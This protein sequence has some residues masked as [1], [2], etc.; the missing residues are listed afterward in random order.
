MTAAGGLALALLF[1]LVT[2][3]SGLSV[4]VELSVTATDPG[5]QSI[6][7]GL[8]AP[9]GSGL[10]GS[11]LVAW[12]ALVLPVGSAGARLGF[13]A[14]SAG[15]SAAV[16]TFVL[17]RRLKFSS[18]SALIATLV[19]VTGGTGVALVA[20]GSPDAMLLPL[21]PGLL[22]CGL[23]W[24]DSSG[25]G[26][27]VVT[28]A[29]LT[30]VAVGSY[31]AMAII[32]AAAAVAA[33]RDA[34]VGRGQLLVATLAAGVLGL[35]HRVGAAE[36]SWRNASSSLGLA[37][38]D[39]TALPRSWAMA[40]GE[41]RLDV[42]GDRLISLVSVTVESLGGLGSLLAVV[43][44]V[45]L[46]RRRDGRGLAWAWI[47]ALLVFCVWAPSAAQDGYRV[48]GLLAWLLV[49][50]GLDW[51][52]RSS[53][54]TGAQVGTAMVGLFLTVAGMVAQ[55]ARVPWVAPLSAETYADRLAQA[56][57][58]GSRWLAEQAGFDRAL[59]TARVGPSS[60]A[61]M[62]L[63]EGLLRQIYDD[64]SPVIAFA[65]AR[66]LLQGYG[67]QFAT[68]PITPARVSVRQLLER[69]PRG[70]VVAIAGGPGL[71]RPVGVDAGGPFTPVGGTAEFWGGEGPFYGLV[72]VAHLAGAPLERRSD[73]AVRL[74][75]EV[76]ESIGTFPVRSM[77]TLGVTA[78]ATGVQV[79]V[80]GRVVARAERGLALAA[81]APN[82]A[83]L[84]ALD[85]EL[86]SGLEI[87]VVGADPTIAE[88]TGWEPCRTLPSGLWVNVSESA[89]AGG[90][91]GRLP[92]VDSSLTFYTTARTDRAPRVGPE[93]SA[94]VAFVRSLLLDPDRPDDVVRDL[95]ADGVPDIP[96]TIG[97]PVVQRVEFRG[98]GPV[99]VEF[100]EAPTFAYARFDGPRSGQR[101]MDV[102]GIVSGEPRFDRGGSRQT[103]VPV[104][105]LDVLGWGWHGLE[106]DGR[107]E[108]RWS[109][110][111]ETELLVQLVRVG[112]V[113]VV[114]E[115]SAAVVD[116]DGAPAT[117]TL[118]VNGASLDPVVM[119]GG[120]QTY[121]WQVP[122]TIWKTGMNRVGLRLSEAV[123]PA[124]LGL[125]DDQRLLGMALRRLELSLAE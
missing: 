12:L 48:V 77:S 61:R 74:A 88:L 97:V 122:A 112:V 54:Q 103:S 35:L 80:H 13:L 66:D 25:R 19:T 4:P 33:A 49:G 118:V 5:A 101:D 83:L 96:V 125:S 17:Y 32:C 60:D 100:G 117:L 7:P 78:D 2:P 93:G 82:G 24:V 63:D 86:E 114:V 51:C 58:A 9:G 124:A 84:I 99:V 89:V 94:T 39:A 87:P 68:V 22:L 47:A 40:F 120:V 95:E 11:T 123:S 23:W 52:W 107:G 18:P 45:T 111:T 56:V 43:G 29:G 108:F 3:G 30:M 62:P 106:R 71:N 37:G 57:P 27:S 69:L 70:S 8:G 16:L 119:T 59:A 102:C 76:G 91:G 110:G 98:A 26:V 44:L 55:Q 46:W 79:K 28:L 121:A 90:L 85:D 92:S 116:L 14:L 21:V 38:G 41:W 104:A 6:G 42:A 67:A 64:V 115:A 10:L 1:P 72:G 36:L 105:D 20:T 15:V 75:L 50:V 113:R 34:T 73:D 109:N 53:G 31:P 65:G 81:V